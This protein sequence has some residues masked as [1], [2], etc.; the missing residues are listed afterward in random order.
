MKATLASYIARHRRST[1]IRHLHRLARWFE[2]AWHNESTD[3]EQN[4]E[5]SVLRRLAPAGFSLAIDAG[6]NVGDW[7]RT[8]LALWPSCRIHAFEVAPPTWEALRN[9]GATHGD[10]FVAH[11]VGL[12]DAPGTTTMHYFPTD[13]RLTADMPRHAGREV[14]TFVA[15]LTTLDAF[16]AEHGV[17]HVDYLK[18][19]VEGAEH[20]VLA[21][22]RGLLGRRAISCLQFEYGAFSVQTRFLL[23]DYYR[24]L[25]ETYEIGKIYPDHV[26]FGAYDWRME[27]FRFSNY[28]CIRRDRRELMDLVRG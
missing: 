2:R 8:A 12:Y 11:N 9:I 24:L 14:T 20:R 28:L 19:D 25:S 1:S 26:D 4:G 15:R 3:S 27:D 16:A 23:Q 7:S 10:R 17:D 13:P 18:I 21:G 22:A 5:Y 6:A